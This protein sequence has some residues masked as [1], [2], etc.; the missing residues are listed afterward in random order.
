MS[1]D[2]YGWIGGLLLAV[3][4]IPQAILSYKKGNAEGVSVIMLLLWLLGEICTLIYVS[5]KKDWPLIIN[6]SANIV[7][8]GIICWYKFFPRNEKSI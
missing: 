7:C 3:C 2:V 6:Y 4:A 5:P 8:I 1:Y